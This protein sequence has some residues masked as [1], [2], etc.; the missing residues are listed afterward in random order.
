MNKTR[1]SRPIPIGSDGAGRL[2]QRARRPRRLKRHE[3]GPGT[4]Q[5]GRITTSAPMTMPMSAASA[6][7]RRLSAKAVTLRTDMR[8]L[9]ED[10]ITWTRLAIISLESGT[11][12]TDATVARLLRNQTDI[13]NAIKPYYGNAAGNELTRAAALA[14]PDRRRP[15]RRGEGR[16]QAKLADAQAR[17]VDER[18]PDRGHVLNSVNPRYWKLGTMKAEM[19]MHLK[20]TTEEAV[21]QAQGR[22]D[23][24]RRRLRQGR[25]STSC[26]CRTCSR[27][28][29]SSSSRHASASRHP[30]VSF[31][32]R[33]SRLGADVDFSAA[34]VRVSS[35]EITNES[36][37]TTTST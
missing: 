15:D 28:A 3:H 25:T 20:L 23:G 24:R 31:P 26:T 35:S 2:L 30:N 7:H 12:D 18:R 9:W 4:R 19:H 16:R 34:E 8:K 13:G 21:A 37:Q 6:P 33:G 10:H 11:P 22:L 32:P 1:A 14:H 27:T 5:P 17:W 29:S 36:M